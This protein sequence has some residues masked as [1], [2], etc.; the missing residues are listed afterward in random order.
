MLIMIVDI[1]AFQIL[2]FRLCVRSIRTLM[3]ISIS[4]EQVL[5]AL[6]LMSDHHE[7]VPTRENELKYANYLK[8]LPR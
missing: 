1:V 6:K 8:V 5:L 7:I 2:G 3:V 4:R